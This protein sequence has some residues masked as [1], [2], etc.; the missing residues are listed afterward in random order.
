MLGHSLGVAVVLETALLYPKKIKS[1]ILLNGSHGHVF[2]YTWMPIIRIPLVE[3]FTYVY[4]AA[5]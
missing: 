1:L 4:I 2:K 5:L 3:N